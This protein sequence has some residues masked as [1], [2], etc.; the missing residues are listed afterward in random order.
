MNRL[1]FLSYLALV[2]PLALPLTADA[3]PPSE[4]L[5]P[6]T[7]KAWI[8]IPDADELRENF[9][10]TQLGKLAQ[11]PLMEPF[12]KD[13]RSQ[14]ENKFSRTSIRLSITLDDLRNIYGGE[15]CL[16][17]LQPEGDDTQH[18]TALLVDISGRRQEANELLD[19]LAEELREKGARRR[20]QMI[21][22]VNVI[23]Y[24][25]PRETGETEAAQA[26]Y[27][28]R[29]DQL[30]AS[31]HQGT[32]QRILASLLGR[33]TRDRSLDEL[34]AF[35]VTQSRC[36]EV[37]DD[38]VP[39]IRWFVDPFGYAQTLRAAAGGR[40]RRGTD[41]LRVLQ[42]QG[43]DAIQG[44][45]GWVSFTAEDADILHRTFVYAPPVDSEENYE[46]AARMLRF[47]SGPAMAPE[48]W[49]PPGVASY[50]TFRWRMQEA[51][52]ASQTLVDEIAGAAVFEDILESLKYDPNGPQI[53]V[54]EGLVQH[55]GERVTFITDYRRPIT[56]TSER[57]LIAFE[58]TESQVVGNTLD[59]A[60]EVDPDATPRMIG[61][62]RV[63][64]ILR[65][66]DD[67]GI[68]EL[69]IA[70]VGFGEFE[71]LDE[72]EGAPLLEHAALTVSF[73][74]L[75]VA[76]HGDFLEQVFEGAE[77]PLEEA[78]DFVRVSE[79]LERF[80]AEP[81]SFRWFNRTD[82]AYETSYELLR[83][84]QMPE[85]DTLLGTV[86]NR[87]LGPEDSDELREQQIRGDE[88]PPFDDIRQHFGPAGLFIQNQE[89]GWMICGIVLA[90]D[91]AEAGEEP[92]DEEPADEEPADEEPADEESA[93]EESADE[94]SADEESA[95]EES[96]DEES[97]DEQ[98]ADEQ[99]AD[100]ESAD[101]Q[102]ADEQP[103]DEQPADEESAGGEPVDGQAG[104]QEVAVPLGPTRIL[105][106]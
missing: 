85:A 72:D 61:D 12:F 93:D 69:D 94:E 59:R 87:M 42:E 3:V 66:E 24:L 77:Q 27:F 8:S 21:Q 9:D 91:D 56:P 80:G 1:A 43:F 50:L 104:G 33:T 68:E 38:A 62:R 52:E 41:M 2:L 101:E 75:I 96:A 29:G 26:Y 60:M 7:T 31:D 39:H 37:S 79:H 40:Q 10:Q 64:D 89:D 28:I 32:I 47:P 5:L 100:E 73:G 63:W 15:I 88:L 102:P 13:L 20:V 4:S 55:L 53:D 44:L 86:L 23:Q 105:V 95:D 17:T 49:V 19:R 51:F 46:L 76:S 48:A 16:A 11:N 34:P 90:K 71:P 54:R 97:A 82:Q 18:A 65:E 67:L 45:G 25:L 98:P 84:D 99:P 58:V 78:D 30:V 92:A 83:Q 14:M 35:T 22:G 103:A 74:Y 36:A 81:S 106:D 70:G 6:D 57:W